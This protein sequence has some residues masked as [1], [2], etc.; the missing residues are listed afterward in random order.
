M[1]ME[2][3]LKYKIISIVNSHNPP[4]S[5]KKLIEQLQNLSGYIIIIDNSNDEIY[6]ESVKNLKVNEK[7]YL[8]HRRD[9][10][11]GEA[12]NF[13]ISKALYFGE[14]NYVLV[15][16]DDAT[17]N[18]NINLLKI[19][20][21]FLNF[22]SENDVL[23][24]NDHENMSMKKVEFIEIKK[25]LGIT[26]FFSPIKIFKKIKFRE[27]FFMDQLDIDFQ[28]DVRRNGGRIILPAEI[29]VNRLPIGREV[30]GKKHIIPLFRI[31]TITKNTLT[32]IFE[33]KVSFI[34]MRYPFY[35][36]FM[37]IIYKS[38]LKKVFKA[39]IWGMI[40]GIFDNNQDNFEDILEK[41]EYFKS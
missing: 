2:N 38:D 27:E 29:I 3:D 24:L 12:L 9:L 40:D 19:L 14:D 11:I 6:E 10:G 32:L 23:F 13:G 41:I 37:H 39:L 25:Y 20:D 22:Y 34:S 18:E 1:E 17:F 26:M 16:E 30:K 21:H 31:Y 36:S 33:R 8:F 28:Y 7:I 5:F 15:V 4:D 35:Y